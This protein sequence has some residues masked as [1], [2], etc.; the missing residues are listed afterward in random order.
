MLIKYI[1]Q[2]CDQECKIQGKK[3]G[4]HQPQTANEHDSN[5]QMKNK[6]KQM[7]RDLQITHVIIHDEVF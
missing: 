1:T 3:A 2:G 4:E 7:N 5:V 6:E